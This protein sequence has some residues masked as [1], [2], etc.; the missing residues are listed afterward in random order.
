MH[1]GRGIVGG[2]EW[3]G[4]V[5]SADWLILDINADPDSVRRAM[6]E[7]QLSAIDISRIHD[8]FS[9]QTSLLPSESQSSLASA[10][11]ASVSVA[12]LVQSSRLT[13]GW[14]DGMIEET[15]KDQGTWV[16]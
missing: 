11:R 1:A 7:G 5:T 10:G 8:Y 13:V 12:S 6:C 14:T 16:E 4:P 15:E 9:V 3:D 2:E